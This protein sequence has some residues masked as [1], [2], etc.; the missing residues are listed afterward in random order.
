MSDERRLAAGYAKHV[1]FCT[2]QRA[3]G[4]RSCGGCG[5][6]E[7]FEHA[8]RQLA[9]LRAQGVRVDASGCLGQCEH[10]PV[11][12]IYPESR[13]FGYRDVAEAETIL[14]RHV[15]DVD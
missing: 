12:V 7:A 6:G 8:R 10:G 4:R 11:L 3:D 2:N 5:A 13:W 1:F 9:G 14:R 15:L